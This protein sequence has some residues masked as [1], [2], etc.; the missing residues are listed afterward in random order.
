MLMRV[1]YDSEDASNPLW[2]CFLDV[3]HPTRQNDLRCVFKMFG[4]LFGAS[5]SQQLKH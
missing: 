1:P 5:L 4:D 3:E 2:V